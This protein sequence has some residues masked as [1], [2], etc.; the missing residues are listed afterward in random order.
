M[1]MTSMKVSGYQQQISAQID[2][3]K[4]DI[5]K[6][7]AQINKA[8][9]NLQVKYADQVSDLETRLTA[10]IKAKDDLKNASELAWDDVKDSVENAKKDLKSALEKTVNKWM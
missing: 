10:L 9:G 4:A 7:K 3:Y 6:L 2:E 1:S 5:D 8:D